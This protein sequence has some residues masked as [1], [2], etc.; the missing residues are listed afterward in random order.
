MY[1][2]VIWPAFRYSLRVF[3]IY[4]TRYVCYTFWALAK[5]IGTQTCKYCCQSM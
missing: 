4:S 2:N 3:N 1:I 5:S